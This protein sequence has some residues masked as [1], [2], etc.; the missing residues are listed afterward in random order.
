MA[1][2][3][4]DGQRTWNGE[5]DEDG[6]RDYK[7]L[8]LILADYTDGP[9]NVMVTPGLPLPGSFW[10]FDGDVDAWATCK[11]NA[12][13]KIHQ[14]REGDR[15][16]LWSLEQSFTTKPLCQD[17][18][19]EDPL[20]Q[21]PKLSGSYVN[22]VR[23]AVVDRW[24]IPGRTSS[25]EQIRGP[26]MEFDEGADQIVIEQN[27][28]DLELGMLAAL[29]NNVNDAPL[30][31]LLPRMV[32]FSNYT[33]QQAFYGLCYCYF[34]RTLTFN[35]NFDTFDR[36]ILDEGNKVLDGYYNNDGH[37][38]INKIAGR[39]ADA[40]NPAHFVRATDRVGNP[41]RVVLNGRGLPAGVRVVG[42]DLTTTTGTGTELSAETEVGYI[43]FEKYKEANL[44]QLGIP[45]DFS[46]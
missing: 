37:Y 32:K 24:G 5:R 39:E 30:W 18:N 23:E 46:C 42:D 11:Q 21:L 40:M 9:A 19:V 38:V 36:D 35:V 22:T 28:L 2:V 26:Q 14:E 44:L 43:H 45:V 27:V 10:A 33:W 17:K 8:W 13:A 16:R 6:H 20:L 1:C 3:L 41:I 7:I 31:G 34:V 12:V 25:Y 4:I 15:H 29:R